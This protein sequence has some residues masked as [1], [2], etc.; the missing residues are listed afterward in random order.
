MTDGVVKFALL[1]T[2]GYVRRYEGE[3]IKGLVNQITETDALN[4]LGAKGYDIYDIEN[5]KDGQIS[6]KTFRLKTKQK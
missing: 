2:A 3:T 4:L 5:G 6:T 1:V